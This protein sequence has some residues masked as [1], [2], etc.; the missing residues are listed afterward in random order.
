M[1][2]DLAILVPCAGVAASFEYNG[3]ARDVITSGERAAATEVNSVLCPSSSSSPPLL[4][5]IGQIARSLALLSL[6]SYA[7]RGA[8]GARGALEVDS[9]LPV[10]E[11]A[12]KLYEVLRAT[13]QVKCSTA[14][15]LWCEIFRPKHRDVTLAHLRAHRR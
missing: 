5:A 14:S 8:G 2:S 1:C 3:A 10:E 9:S 12:K 15:Y 7:R 6:G 13:Q 4:A 11:Q